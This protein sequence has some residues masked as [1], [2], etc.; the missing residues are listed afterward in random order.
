M[1]LVGVSRDPD[2]QEIQSYR[3]GG[4][5]VSG[6]VY[7]GSVVVFE[8]RVESWEVS[9]P[10]L[11][12]GRHL[13]I[14]RDADPRLDLLLLGLGARFVVPAADVLRTLAEWRLPHEL[15]NTAA[16]CRTFNLLLAEGRRVAA[17]LIA[18]PEEPAAAPGGAPPRSL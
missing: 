14:F 7:R 13:E 1:R 4:F 16:A 17:A 11:L 6:R 3:P 5:T 15:M 2:R 8:D 18:L 12:E 10:V 9:D